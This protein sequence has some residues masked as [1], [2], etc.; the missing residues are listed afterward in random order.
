MNT[1][2]FPYA[3]LSDSDPILTVASVRLDGLDRSQ[4]VKKEDAA[5]PLHDGP[6]TWRRA[7]LS[8]ELSCDPDRI[9]DFEREHG[10][11]SVMVV[12]NCLPTN[13]RHPVRL[14]R[15]EVE[16]GRWSGILELDRDNVCDRIALA[17]ILTATVGGVPYRPVATA[18][19]WTVYADE[20]ESL[21]FKGTLKVQWR[22]F[23]LLDAPLPARDFPKSTHVVA[24]N[25]GVPE[26]WLNSGFDGLDS[27]LKDRKDRRGADKGLHDF[28]RTG[29][30]RSVWLALIADALAA[31]RGGETDEPDWPEQPWQ[32]EILKLV[33]SEV[34]P[35][36]SERELLT[37][38]ARDWRESPA[39]GEFFA[40]AE[41]V[42]SDIVKANESLRRFV[43]NYHGEV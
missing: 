37:L 38:A 9:R 16:I 4:L 27:L 17:T 42:V 11:V 23:K 22:N 7:E 21:R 10:L 41:A 18:P 35:G 40:R 20:P 1:V 2:L 15:S 33:L 31:V 36:K 34:A 24:F 25:G 26:L 6:K 43:Q 12:A 5:V 8:L 39:T 13:V 32:A 14:F 3:T 28:Q 19:N 30:A 29:I